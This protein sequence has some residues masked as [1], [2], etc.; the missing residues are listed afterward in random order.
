LP[1]LPFTP[2]LGTLK[3]IGISSLH[4]KKGCEIDISMLLPH[5]K[6]IVD[7]VKE[8]NSSLS[9]NNNF[10][11]VKTIDPAELM[12][13]TWREAL[14]SHPEVSELKEIEDDIISKTNLDGTIVD[15]L[16]TTKTIEGKLI[17]L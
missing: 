2:K 15:G 5:F 17:K 1:K 12:I 9:L 13:Q 16:E 10:E 6:T 4:N 7:V 11:G 8:N 3:V 14:S